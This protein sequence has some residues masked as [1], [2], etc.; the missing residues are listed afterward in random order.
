M[1]RYFKRNTAYVDVLHAVNVDKFVDAV[2]VRESRYDGRL[3][4]HATLLHASSD[5]VPR[6]PLSLEEL[7]R[8][9]AERL[10]R[11]LMSRQHFEMRRLAILLAA[12]PSDEHLDSN[13]WKILNN[14]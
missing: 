1:R 11:D 14:H 12:V 2:A 10:K 7:L 3:A 13:E 5:H 4:F 6:D 8:Q 9:A